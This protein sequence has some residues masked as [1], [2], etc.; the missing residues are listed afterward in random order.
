M[1][2]NASCSIAALVLCGFAYKTNGATFNI[3]NGD[4]AALKSAI[5][6]ANVNGENDTIIL[7]GNGTYSL[8]SAESVTEDEGADGLPIIGSDNNHTVAISGN[9]AMIERASSSQQSFRILHLT[10]EADV[11]L[12]DLTLRNG[13]IVMPDGGNA[14]GF[15]GGGG[16]IYVDSGTLTLN[17][18]TF[19]DNSAKGGNG[20]MGSGSGGW[21]G[22]G[23]GGAVYSVGGWRTTTVSGCTFANNS[24]GGGDGGN[25]DPVNGGFGGEGG[26]AF[27]GAIATD[28]YAL[29]NLSNCVFNNNATTGGAPGLASGS[30]FDDG[31]PG[32]AYG[33]AVTS[34]S[35]TNVSVCSFNANS[36]LLGGAIS[37]TYSIVMTDSTITNNVG[38]FG[39]GMYIGGVNYAIIT[40]CEFTNNSGGFGGALSDYGYVTVKDTTFD[41]NSGTYGGAIFQQW[42]FGGLTLSGCTFLN[43]I[44]NADSPDDPAFLGGGA[45]HNQGGVSAL[46][47]TFYHNTSATNGGAIF[48]GNRSEQPAGVRLRVENCTF[49]ENT[50]SASGGGIYAAPA[51]GAAISVDF[52]NTIFKLSNVVDAGGAFHFLSQGHNISDD[53]G[54]GYFYGAGDQ[55][56]TDPKLDPSGLQNN[57]GPTQTIALL[58]NSPAIDAGDDTIAQPRDQRHYLR[59]GTGDIG[60]FEFNGTLAPVSAASRKTHGGSGIFD[61]D[62]P[63]AGNFGIECRSGQTAGNHKL[64]V[65]FASPIGLTGASLTSGVGHIDSVDVNGSRVSIN[66]SGVTNAERITVRLSGVDDGVHSADSNITMAVLSGDTNADGFV[67]S[68]DIAQTKSQSG[69]GVNYFNFREDVTVDGGINSADIALTKSKSG[70]ALP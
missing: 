68:A 59:F 64:I 62:L 65:E 1:K 7:A 58:P 70:T 46:N 27:G 21:G 55:I 3:A 13:R 39:G 45:I 51:G 33:G 48:D 10:T 69:Q 15:D 61:I 63:L 54:S 11:T 2:I 31:N 14:S 44:A 29:L 4:I 56:N 32:L 43:N 24:A 47:C 37:A 25:A 41:G 36:A 42:N 20:A 19:I 22:T 17:N 8:I 40:R 38:A 30:D 6:S 5:N 18:C 16:A 60:A 23:F 50:A 67:N 52:G 34:N 49:Q 57:G 53:G 35:I 28:E 66:L 9:D 12:S 26:E